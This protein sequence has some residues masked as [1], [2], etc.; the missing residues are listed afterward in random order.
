MERN[1]REIYRHMTVKAA[2]HRTL[3]MVHTS[4]ISQIKKNIY[5]T[6]TT[7]EVVRY[8][9]ALKQLRET[10]TDCRVCQDKDAKQ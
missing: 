7:A 1:T 5:S 3:T 2:K 10:Y 6:Y 4:C 8:L 9:P